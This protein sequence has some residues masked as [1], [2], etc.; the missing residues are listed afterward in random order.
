MGIGI[1]SS[2]ESSLLGG[3]LDPP[4]PVQ[5]GGDV[6]VSLVLPFSS[7]VSV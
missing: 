6:I 3:L 7:S 1:A 2:L 4:L 5:G